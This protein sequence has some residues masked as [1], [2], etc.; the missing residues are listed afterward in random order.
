MNVLCN[1]LNE[2]LRD[3]QEWFQCNE[4]ALDVLKTHYMVHLETD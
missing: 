1:R 4:L 2:D 3:I